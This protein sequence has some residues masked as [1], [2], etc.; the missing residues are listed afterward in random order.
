MECSGTSGNTTAD[1]GY[2]S[3]MLRQ[4][5]PF[6]LMYDTMSVSYAVL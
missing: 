3:C 6:V 4:N 1:N 5:I 2:L